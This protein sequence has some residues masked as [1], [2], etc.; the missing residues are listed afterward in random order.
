[1]AKGR[2]RLPTAMKAAKGTLQPCRTNDDEPN[3]IALSELPDPPEYLSQTGR[4]VYYGT[5]GDLQEYG[6][7]NRINFTIFVM[8]CTQVAIYYDAI[9]NIHKTG[10]IIQDAGGGPRINP[11]VKIAND[12]LA[13]LM[14][15]ACEFGLTP[16]SASKVN[17]VKREVNAKSD[18]IKRLQKK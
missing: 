9:E 2:K 16:A 18:L 13:A 3:Y 1:M 6:I 12:S 14:R 15:V 7:L 17:A 8:Y 10:V 4:D 5:A 11:Y